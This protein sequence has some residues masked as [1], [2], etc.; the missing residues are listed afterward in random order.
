[1]NIDDISKRFKTFAYWGPGLLV[2]GCIS[3]IFLSAKPLDRGIYYA[4]LVNPIS[5]LGLLIGLGFCVYRLSAYLER[6]P[7]E[8]L[9]PNISVM[10]MQSRSGGSSIAKEPERGVQEGT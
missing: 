7:M 6:H 1:M 9:S 5:C 4:Y 8:Y 2:I 10:N 3:L